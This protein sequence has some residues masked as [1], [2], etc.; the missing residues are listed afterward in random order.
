MEISIGLIAGLYFV[1]F[2]IIFTVASYLGMRRSKVFDEYSVAGRTIGG[3]VNGLAG[4]E[5]Y[6]S[7][8]L[9][10][11]MTAIVVSMGFPYMGTLIPFALSI[12]IFMALIGP[13]ARNTG[14]RTLIELIEARYGRAVAYLVLAINLLFV[15]MFMI[16]QMKAVGI[17]VEYIFGIPLSLAIIIGGLI[18]TAWCVIGGMYGITWSQFIQGLVVLS[19]ISITAASVLRAIGVANW[20]NPYLGYGEL[21]P[22]M[23]SIGFFE[24]KASPKWYLSLVIVGLGGAAASPQMFIIS[25]RAKNASSVRWALSWMVFFI[26]LVYACAMALA[27]A[28]TYWIKTTGIVIKPEQ[29]DYALFM[30]CD[31]LTHPLIAA[32]VVYSSFVEAISTITTLIIFCGTVGVTHVYIPLKK[33]VKKSVETSDRERKIALAIAMTITGIAFTFITLSPPTLLAI[34]I[35]WGWEL[36]TC[37]LLIPCFFAFWWKRV[38]RWGVLAS[39][40]TG[41]MVILTQGWTGPLIKLPFYGCLVF[42]PLATLVNV[43]VSYLT[44]PDSARTL[45]DR[46]HGFTDYSEK[47]YSG[48][49][50]PVSLGILSILML[51]FALIGL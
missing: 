33:L 49:L 28:A 42:L 26:G 13:Y 17:C 35:L 27:F 32:Y 18:V 29:A 3:F 19:A 8:F 40:L 14:A 11:G 4:M 16:G 31:A 20:F 36:L 43:I 34:P 45:V 6:L 24:L 12:A 46:W 5:S 25:A 21:S 22:I 9:F 15:A 7:A 47:R 41:A 10:M 1:I 44:P 50:L 51:I 37:T 48:N 23:E 39:I 30:V 38:T 2:G